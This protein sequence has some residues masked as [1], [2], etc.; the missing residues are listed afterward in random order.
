MHFGDEQ[1]IN[2]SMHMDELSMDPTVVVYNSALQQSRKTKRSRPIGGCDA[3]G[4]MFSCMRI[5]L[6][7]AV[8]CIY[9]ST[10][11]ATSTLIVRSSQPFHQCIFITSTNAIK[12]HQ[13]NRSKAI[14]RPRHPAHL[15]ASHW[16]SKASS[17]FYSE[18]I[19]Y[20]LRLTT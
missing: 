6:T 3:A 18:S 16:Q 5:T 9:T 10:S 7:S 11:R 8:N 17:Q 13:N 20:S 4:F 19:G 12:C 2:K 14:C 15:C 1:S